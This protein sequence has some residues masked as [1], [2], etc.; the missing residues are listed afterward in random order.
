[1]LPILNKKFS[2]RLRQINEKNCENLLA[3]FKKAEKPAKG[4]SK[5]QLYSRVAG[6]ISDYCFHAKKWT[7]D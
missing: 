1:M 7:P 3:N 2:N 6:E 5:A 4:D